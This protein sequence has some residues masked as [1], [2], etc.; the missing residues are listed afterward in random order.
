MLPGRPKSNWLT[1]PL[2]QEALDLFGKAVRRLEP[3]VVTGAGEDDDARVGQAGGVGMRVSGGD[4]AVLSS[5]EDQRGYLGSGQ[6]AA[7]LWTVWKLPCETSRRHARVQSALHPLRR[8]G[9]RKPLPSQRRFGFSEDERPQHRR[10]E[11]ELVGRERAVHLQAIGV[12]EH[13]PVQ[14]LGIPCRELR[15]DPAA[16]AAAQ[17]DGPLQTERVPQVEQPED[18][19][20]RSIDPSEG[21]RVVEAGQARRDDL[22]AS[23]ERLVT[24]CPPVARRVVEPEQRLAAARADDARGAAAHVLD[25]LRRHADTEARAPA[26]DTPSAGG[27]T[28]T[29]RRWGMTSRAN[30]STLLRVR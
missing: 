1:R 28:L 8:L 25:T 15:G 20:F 5:P 4:E 18:D 19:V 17:Q 30:S 16:E 11:G 9:V 29:P 14:T 12:D 7:E 21:C 22:V 13:Q 23:D 26:R 10:R 3:G 27:S 2:A 6:P 24:A